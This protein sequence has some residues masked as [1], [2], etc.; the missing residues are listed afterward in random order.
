MRFKGTLVATWLVFGVTGLGCANQAKLAPMDPS[1]PIETKGGYKQGGKPLARDSM[2]ERLGEEPASESDIATAKTLAVM[3]QVLGAVGGALLGWPIGE[4]LGGVEKPHWGLAIAGGATIA[5]AVP[6]A[7]W[8]DSK[9]SQAVDSH[10]RSLGK[11]AAERA[12]AQVRV[13]ECIPCLASLPG[14]QDH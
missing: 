13:A 3:G 8:S 14:R 12:P 2:L 9:V 7:L 11:P 10:N 4:K 5:V 6:L 1:S